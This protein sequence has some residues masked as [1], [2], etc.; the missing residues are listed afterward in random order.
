MSEF[1]ERRGIVSAVPTPTPQR[2]SQTSLGYANLG[3]PSQLTVDEDND[4]NWPEV[5]LEGQSVD[6]EYK[7]YNQSKRT[8]IDQDLLSYW[9]VSHVT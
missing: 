4:M 2:T 9:E 5:S 7:S 8:A 6:E 3:L 1:R